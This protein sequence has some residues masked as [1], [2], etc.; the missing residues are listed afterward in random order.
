MCIVSCEFQR[1]VQSCSS[2]CRG[3]SSCCWARSSW[4]IASRLHL[5]CPTMFRALAG[6]FGSSVTS[7]WPMLTFTQSCSVTWMPHVDAHLANSFLHTGPTVGDDVHCT[8]SD[9]PLR[10]HGLQFT[11]NEVGG[12]AARR[13]TDSQTLVVSHEVVKPWP[14]WRSSCSKTSTCLWWWHMWRNAGVRPWCLTLPPRSTAEQDVPKAHVGS[15]I[16]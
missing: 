9:G 1:V 8:L 4:V 2:L 14:P 10:Q 6:I 16:A 7:L 11:G 13:W 3:R 5:K 15:G 12:V